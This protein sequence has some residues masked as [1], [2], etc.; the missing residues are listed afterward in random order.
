MIDPMNKILK[1]SPPTFFDSAR[2]RTSAVFLKAHP[3]TW[4]YHEEPGQM[5]RPR[6]AATIR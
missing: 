6:V 5:S 1:A 4:K 2:E 3:L